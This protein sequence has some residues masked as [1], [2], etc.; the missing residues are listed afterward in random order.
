[1]VYGAQSIAPE[2]TKIMPK[3]WGISHI[4]FRVRKQQEMNA[5]TQIMLTFFIQSKIPVHVMVSLM[6]RVDLLISMNL[7]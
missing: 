6:L 3:P 2:K 4:V 5:S 7:P 1:M